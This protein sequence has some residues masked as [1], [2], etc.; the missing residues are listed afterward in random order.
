MQLQTCGCVASSYQRQFY[1][2][3]ISPSGFERCRIHDNDEFDRHLTRAEGTESTLKRPFCA[4]FE[5]EACDMITSNRGRIVAKFWYCTS[6]SKGLQEH[7]NSR[8]SKMK[9]MKWQAQ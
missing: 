7:V 3:A 5:E 9:R 1:R 8:S 2:T 4:Y 6:V